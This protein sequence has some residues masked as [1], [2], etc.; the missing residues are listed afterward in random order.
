MLQKVLI[1]MALLGLVGCDAMRSPAAI[2]ESEN[3][4]LLRVYEVPL[5]R[6]EDIATSLAMALGPVGS[7]RRVGE[8]NQVLVLAPSV[9][10]SSIASS[11]EAMVKNTTPDGDES[12]DLAVR[13]DAWIVD[14]A[15]VQD[16]RLA[17][18]ASV[19]ELMSRESGVAS[20]RLYTVQSSQAVANGGG[21]K[22]SDNLAIVEGQLRPATNGVR[23]RLEVLDLKGFE[24]RVDT[25][26]PYGQ[27]V[28]LGQAA[29]NAEAGSRFVIVRA[30]KL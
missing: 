25:L 17:P 13:V 4:K 11:I 28:V 21:F 18:I 19:L 24:V 29:A 10:H 22:S 3:P 20:Y 14:A 30:T 9:M 27:F 1:L 5:E 16:E 26:L 7:V 12:T 23:A 8:S 15:D 2:P 6:S